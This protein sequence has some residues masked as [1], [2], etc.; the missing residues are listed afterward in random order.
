MS[1]NAEGEHIPVPTT[2]APVLAAAPPPS[3][4]LQE[5]HPQNPPYV[6]QM[7]EDIISKATAYFPQSSSVTPLTFS[8]QFNPSQYPL[9]PQSYN[10]HHWSPSDV[11]AQPMHHMMAQPQVPIS[12]SQIPSPSV[13]PRSHL[14][15]DILHILES[16]FTSDSADNQARKDQQISRVAEELRVKVRLSRYTRVRDQLSDSEDEVSEQG[17]ESDISEDESEDGSEKNSEDPM[18]NQKVNPQSDIDDEADLVDGSGDEEEERAKNNK[19]LAKLK[20]EIE[21]IIGI[22]ESA[23]G[24]TEEAA[25]TMTTTIQP[26]EKPTIT[27]ELELLTETEAVAEALEHVQ[28]STIAEPEDAP[29]VTS[30]PE[31]PSVTELLAKVKSQIDQLNKSSEPTSIIIPSETRLK[32]ESPPNPDPETVTPASLSTP[33]TVEA[34]PAPQGSSSQ[35][36]PQ[37]SNPR[38]KAPPKKRVGRSADSGDESDDEGQ[39]S[40]LATAGPTTANELKEPPSEVVEVPFTRVTDEE[41]K[42][43]NPFG[44]ISSLIGNVL[45]IQGTAGLGYDRVLDEGTLVCQKDGLVIGKIFET[46]G[47]V[48][49]PHYSIRLPNHILASHPRN[50][51][52]GLDLSPGLVMYY[53]PTHSNFVFTAELRAQPKGTDASNFYDEEVGNADEIEFSD[54][55]AE[56]AYRKAC[57]LAK[58]T[59]NDS[60]PNPHHQ[61]HPRENNHQDHARANN[62][63]QVSENGRRMFVKMTS[64]RLNY[65]TD[66]GDLPSQ[67]GTVESDYSLLQRPKASNDPSMSMSTPTHS[68]NKQS[69][70]Q[71]SRG[72]KRAPG[73]RDRNRKKFPSQTSHASSSQPGPTSSV[74]GTNGGSNH[75]NGNS[76]ANFQADRTST[77][78]GIQSQLNSLPANPNSN[79]LQS[80]R[81]VQGSLM[82]TLGNM[83]MNFVTQPPSHSL[84]QSMH[85]LPYTPMWTAPNGMSMTQNPMM[86]SMMMNQ[87]AYYQSN[88]GIP[89]YNP[90]LPGH[91][92]NPILQFGLQHPNF[93]SVPPA[94]QLSSQ[95]PSSNPSF[96]FSQLSQQPQTHQT[97]N[98]AQNNQPSH[99][100]PTAPNFSTG[101]HFNPSFYRPP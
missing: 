42:S 55:E 14:P 54:D 75:P 3:Q 57:K 79:L 27:N 35:V 47:S 66:D 15:Q 74:S 85:S 51:K 68:N 101:G 65:G 5:S 88:A 16:D 6:N 77:N 92:S 9:G 93:A 87:N 100:F 17:K 59:A 53:L 82:S 49:N 95:H 41:L 20:M 28:I 8:N 76:R 71:R 46:F 97:Q 18:N 80:P 31:D 45:V 11:S 44:S 12:S 52:E 99:P 72:K 32:E 29:A 96:Q 61:N 21:S 1:G 84:Q 22:P 62:S 60:H 86:M 2:S 26:D 90:H 25:E 91:S 30:I 81:D 10:M 37:T 34:K 39:E 78:P 43:I 24:P 94:Q 36:K 67:S 56:A 7:V 70:S 48:T 40:Y 13:D 63:V 69:S 64:D 89:S 33:T 50:D 98:Q 4:S 73:G 83:N 38:K 58:K 23:T 19:V